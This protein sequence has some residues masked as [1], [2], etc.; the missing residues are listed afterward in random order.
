MVMFI[1]GVLF[2]RVAMNGIEIVKYYVGDD[3]GEGGIQEE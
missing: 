2:A 1:N 3:D